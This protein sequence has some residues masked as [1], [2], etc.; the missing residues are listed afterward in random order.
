MLQITSILL[1]STIFSQICNHVR[2]SYKD[3]HRAH[4]L[5]ETDRKDAQPSLSGNSNFNLPT[6]EYKLRLAFLVD[7]KIDVNKDNLVQLDE[8]VQWL[9]ECHNRYVQQDANRHWS[10]LKKTSD[11]RLK[12][13]DYA[14]Q[15]YSHFEAL[16]KQLVDREQI[17]K[18]KNSHDYHVRRDKRRWKAADLD[19]DGYLTRDEY[20]VFLH[21]DY[22]DGMH[23]LM[24]EEKF[25]LMDKNHDKRISFEE[26]I[27][28]LTPTEIYHNAEQREKWLEDERAIFKAKLDLNHDDHLDESE[29]SYWMPNIELKEQSIKEAQQLMQAADENRDHRLTKEEILASYHEFANSHATDFGEFLKL[30]QLNHDEL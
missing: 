6:D 5:K 9:R 21:P 16:I 13:E 14:S 12:W 7:E 29:F 18:V 30:G 1:F 11:D 24:I 10:A 22:F 28:N 19:H 4:S 3:S 8:L 27:S 25:E 2:S 23:S 15:E 17:D 20:R 26:F